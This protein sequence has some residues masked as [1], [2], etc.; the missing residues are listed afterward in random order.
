MSL[1]KFI[2]ERLEV[3]K[4]REQQSRKDFEIQAIR[5][6]ARDERMRVSK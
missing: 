1:K 6:R 3:A 5:L 4:L 2:R